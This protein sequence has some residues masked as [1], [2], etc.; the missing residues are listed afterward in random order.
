MVS[1]SCFLKDFFKT[2]F[3]INIYSI[4][5]CLQGKL[6]QDN[7][8]SDIRKQLPTGY[9]QTFTVS[10]VFEWSFPALTGVSA[11]AYLLQN[12]VIAIVRN[13]KHPENNVR[14]G[15]RLGLS[16]WLWVRVRFRV[17]VTGF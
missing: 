8:D 15:L 2:Y 12:A 10:A 11:L 14:T 13:Q 4:E 3:H 5:H 6:V 1:L 9:P 7:D 17:W 16:L